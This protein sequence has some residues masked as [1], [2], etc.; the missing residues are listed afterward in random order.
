MFT[1]YSASYFVSSYSAVLKSSIRNDSA[2]LLFFVAFILV[3]CGDVRLG[4]FCSV[5]LAI[6][7]PDEF[8]VLPLL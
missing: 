8:L 4:I 3:L 6:S 1:A 7:S 5:F 2:L